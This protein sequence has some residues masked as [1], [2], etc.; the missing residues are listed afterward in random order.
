ML[1]DGF[2]AEAIDLAFTGT[3]TPNNKN[4]T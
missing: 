3:T 4:I 1:P 2:E